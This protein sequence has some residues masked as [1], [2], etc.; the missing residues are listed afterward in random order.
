MESGPVLTEEELCMIHVWKLC[1]SLLSLMS[2]V[3]TA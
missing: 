2:V 3:P 1:F